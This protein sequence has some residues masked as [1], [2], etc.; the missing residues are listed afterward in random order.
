[1]KKVKYRLVYNR[2]KLLNSKGT[3]LI[4]VEAS[5]GKHKTYFGTQIYI[6]PEEWDQ[7]RSNII[8]HPNADDLNLWLYEFIIRL[9]SMELAM[10][11]KG[12]TPTPSLLKNAFENKHTHKQTFKSFCIESIQNSSRKKS[13]KHNLL[14]T[15]R[16]IS[17]FCPS[18]TWEDLNYIFL[19]EF[20]HWMEQ[21]NYAINTVAKHLRNLRTLINEAI[22]TG[23]L[24]AETNPFNQYT[25]KCAKTTHRFLKPEK[26]TAMENIQLEG[27]LSHVRDAFLFCCYTG[28]RY[29][30]FIRLNSNHISNLNGEPWL[31]MKTKKTGNDIQIPLRLIFGGKA[32]KILERYSSIEDFAKIGKNAHVNQRLSELRQELQIETRITF[33][34]ARHTCATLLCHHGIPITTI[35]KI[36]GHSSVTTTQIYSEVMTETIARDLSNGFG[37]RSISSTKENGT[38]TKNK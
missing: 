17:D 13:T 23:H 27:K 37:I 24:S 3:A 30:D 11:K 4:Q 14:G 29:S 32:L 12:I 19:K 7:R 1:M 26:L 20:E 28:L 31:K 15:V 38:M 25:I 36:L 9:E 6:R 22:A 2:K 33:H 35:Q 10:W 21:K 8:N 34:S 5:L 18:N 16:L